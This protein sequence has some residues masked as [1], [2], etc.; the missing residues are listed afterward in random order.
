MEFGPIYER[1]LKINELNIEKAP[2]PE[3]S[4][5]R[6]EFI[7]KIKQEQPSVPKQLPMTHMNKSRRS[8]S[9]SYYLSPQEQKKLDSTLDQ[10][11]ELEKE[12]TVRKVKEEVVNLEEKYD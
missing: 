8:V 5:Q 6:E 11:P 7:Q 10:Q 2:T 3:R 9:Q 4:E 1:F 12:D